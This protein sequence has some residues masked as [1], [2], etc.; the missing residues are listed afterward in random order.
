MLYDL[1]GQGHNVHCLMFHYEQRHFKELDYA[2]RHCE[3]MSVLSTLLLLPQ[4]AGSEL[5]DGVG[6][7][8]VPNRNAILLSHA[9]NLA[10][11]V[12]AD[13]I[14]YACNKDDEAVFPDCRQAFVDA[15]NAAIKSA[16]YTVEIC[17]PYI[18]K[19]KAWIARLGSDLGVPL[20]ETW[21]CYRG[22]KEPCGECAA[23]RKR[24]EGLNACPA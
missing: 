1:K 2:K 11:V 15:M 8:I 5:T 6:G 19:S 7:I 17:A 4:L 13:T 16:G 12:G 14:T 18:D 10:A 22:G 9:V 23:C 21:S 24:E 3:R 20:S